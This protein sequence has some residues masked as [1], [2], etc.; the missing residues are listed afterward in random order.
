MGSTKMFEENLATNRGNSTGQV[1]IVSPMSL[2]LKKMGTQHGHP[3]E[4]RM[5]VGKDTKL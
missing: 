2:K 5:D 4:N 3:T 1:K